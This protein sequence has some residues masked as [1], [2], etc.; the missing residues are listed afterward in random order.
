MIVLGFLAILTVAVITFTAQTR[1]ERLAGRAYVSVAQTRQLLNTALTRAMED[2]DAAAADAAIPPFQ[3]IGSMDYE[4]AFLSDSIGFEDEK[5]YFPLSNGL[6]SPAYNNSLNSAKWQ[7][8]A[9]LEGKVLGRVGYIIINCSGLLDANEVGGLNASSHYIK[10][11]PGLSPQEIQLSRNVRI[12]DEFNGSASSFPLL[13]AAHPEGRLYSNSDPDLAPGLAFVYNRN[14]A[15]KRFETLRDVRELS[16]ISSPNIL[17]KGIRSFSTFS[18]DPRTDQRTFMG[19]NSATLNFEAVEQSLPPTV[20]DSAFVLNQLRDYID[21]DT[22]PTDI[23]RSV[24]PVPLINEFVL[25]LSTHFT[26]ILSKNT[27]G[28]TIVEHVSVS[29][30]YAVAL[31]V[32]YPFF[33][34]TNSSTFSAKLGSLL[35]PRPPATALLG[36]IGSWTNSFVIPDDVTEPSRIPPNEPYSY[37]LQKESTTLIINSAGELIEL[38]ENLAHNISFSELICFDTEVGAPVDRVEHFVFPMEDAVNGTWLPQIEELA[39]RLFNNNAATQE[40]THFEIGKAALD[41][42]LN[43]DASRTSQWFAVGNADS[44]NRFE[45]SLGDMNKD[46]IDTIDTPDQTELMFIR[47]ADRIDTPYEFTY[48]LYDSSKPW[49]TFQMLKEND[50]DNTRFVMANLCTYTQGR[51]PRTGLVNPYTPHTNTIAAVFMNMPTHDFNPPNVQKLDAGQATQAAERFI[52]YVATNGWPSSAAGY[53]S[54]LFKNIVKDDDN[55]WVMESF[56]RNTY[57][58]FNPRDTLYTI[59]LAAQG[60]TDYD[61]NG[62]ISGDEVR[63]TQKAVAYIWRDPETGKAACVF[64]GLSDTL[65]KDIEWATLLQAFRP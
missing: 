45:S 26:P 5:D 59:L 21:L 37:V 52:D 1:S 6:I 38:F 62:T 61:N 43:W 13:D 32:W 34:Y 46:L 4:N 35:E 10:R 40:A 41:P 51:K 60:G 30:T 25:T 31:E 24:E 7:P 50:A 28:E 14:N 54:G 29:N 18:F 20:T 8:V 16:N 64:Y 44:S 2:I 65:Q 49:K 33:G 17:T 42:R 63:A 11:G 55:P 12:I 23:E 15:W 58:L 22:I 39:E 47:N 27:N 57:E 36:D 53:G 3:T 9:N 19:T 56:F 48:L